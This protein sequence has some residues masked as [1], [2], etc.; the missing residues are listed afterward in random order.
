MP[1]YRAQSPEHLEAEKKIIFRR[2]RCSGMS[3][4]AWY[5]TGIVNNGHRVLVSVLPCLRVSLGFKG[6]PSR[7]G[8]PPKV[9]G[10]SRKALKRGSPKGEQILGFAE[11][12][13]A[14]LELFWG[15]LSDNPLHP[16]SKNP[17]Y[18][19]SIPRPQQTG[20]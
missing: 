8:V 9:K 14:T 6:F 13:L 19:M 16:H 1:T 5:F 7:F 3:G 2:N 10:E 12:G 4:N 17:T 11:K 20:K 15:S 18:L